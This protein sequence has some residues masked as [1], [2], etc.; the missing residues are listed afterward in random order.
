MSATVQ[1]KDK[2]KSKKER[3]H[4]ELKKRLSCGCSHCIKC[5]HCIHAQAVARTAARRKA[6]RTAGKGGSTN[7]KGETVKDDDGSLRDL[8]ATAHDVFAASRNRNS[9]GDQEQMTPPV[10]SRVAETTPKK[11]ICPDAVTPAG[12][13]RVKSK[14]HYAAIRETN[15][16]YLHR[17]VSCEADAA[18]F[19]R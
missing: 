1:Q 17:D 14:A 7:G 6:A 15:S 8:A 3:Q 11:T 12:S 16:R 19:C 4:C 9:D 10:A 18:S 2:V 13:S 5:V